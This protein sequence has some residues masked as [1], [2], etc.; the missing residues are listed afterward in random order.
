MRPSQIPNPQAHD[1][2]QLNPDSIRPAC[3]GAPNWVIPALDS[4]PWVV[5]RR[6]HA[7]A[8]QIAVGVRGSS[9][10]ERW[11]SFL[12]TELITRVVSPTELLTVAQS[13]ISDLRTPAFNA[14]QQLIERWCDLPL[15]WGPTGSVGFELATGHKVATNCSDLDV[16]IRAE[17]RISL[18][19]ARWIY[20]RATGLP[21]KVDIRVET[22]ESGFSLEEY[23]CTRSTILLRYPES[24]RLGNDPWAKNTQ[25]AES[26][27]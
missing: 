8:G 5:V 20:E 10:S 25:A 26:T 15:P 11:G 9:R 17:T 21:T 23:A 13:S 18:E 19:R 6:A 16:A 1:L 14:L 27:P 2:L 4:C 3:I 7:P 24:V 22:P 12:S